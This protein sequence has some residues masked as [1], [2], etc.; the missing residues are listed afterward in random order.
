VSEPSDGGAALAVLFDLDGLLIDS[1]PVWYEVEYALVERLGGQWSRAHQA[2]CMGGTLD[3]SCAYILELTGADVSAEKIRDE[4]LTEMAA[5]F[6]ASL[7]LHHGAADLLDALEARGLPIGLV[8]SSYRVILDAALDTIGRDRFAVT[9]SGEDV[10]H[11]KPHPEP[12]LTACERLG[13]APERTVVLEDA[14]LG[15]T[16][17]E[18]A[19]CVVVAVPTVARIEATPRRPVVSSLVDIDVDWLVNLVRTAGRP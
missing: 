13:V 17:A 9:V 1:E 18:S 14:P 16:S 19:G 11:G 12:Y 10:T 8:T 7:P 2:E 15:V 6:H 3:R 4:L 5:H